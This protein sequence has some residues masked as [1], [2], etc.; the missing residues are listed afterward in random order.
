MLNKVHTWRDCDA[1]YEMYTG[2]YTFDP[3]S[4]YKFGPKCH[5]VH[6]GVCTFPR[7]TALLMYTSLI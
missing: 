4:D 3:R 7:T 6:T 5:F 1:F 2:V